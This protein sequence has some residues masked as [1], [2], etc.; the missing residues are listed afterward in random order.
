MTDS[1]RRRGRGGAEGDGFRGGF[2]LGAAVGAVITLIVALRR[3]DQLR[4][5]LAAIVGQRHHEPSKSSEVLDRATV[6]GEPSDEVPPAIEREIHDD[7][8][9]DGAEHAAPAGGDRASVTA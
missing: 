4:Q 5:W 8:M 1:W 3:G 9:V 7:D 6:D 2:A